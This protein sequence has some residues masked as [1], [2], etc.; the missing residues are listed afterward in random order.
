[1]PNSGTVKIIPQVQET[2]QA[3]GDTFSL[4][5]SSLALYVF[6]FMNY[7]SIVFYCGVL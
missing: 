3:G 2:S 4:V 6:R 7:R 1:M 5:G